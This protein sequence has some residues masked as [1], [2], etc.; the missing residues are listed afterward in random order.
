VAF[1]VKNKILQKMGL[2]KG[3]TNNLNGRPK[4][5]K[6]RVSRDLKQW[7][8]DFLTNQVDKIEKDWET[9]E[10]K[11]RIAA[12][13]QL[14]KYTIPTLQAVNNRINWQALSEN[15]IDTILNKL[16]NDHANATRQNRISQ[17]LSGRQEN[18]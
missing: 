6:G 15:D 3:Q 12:F 18:N 2:K 8:S 13:Q 9:L 1:F 11:D 7:I 16:I 17:T 4:G 14:L 5:A 10:P